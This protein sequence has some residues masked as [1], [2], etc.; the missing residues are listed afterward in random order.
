MPEIEP[1]TKHAKPRG[2]A[3]W[4]STTR[5]TSA[6]PSRRCSTWKATRWTAAEGGGEGLD[7]FEQATF[8][9]VLLD[10]MMPDRSGMEVLDEIRKRDRDTPI[11]LITAYGSVEVAV[12]ALKSGANDYFFE[13]LGQREA[14]DRDRP[15]DRA[16]ALEHENRS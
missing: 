3:S 13:A 5:R 9:L 6:N 11:F 1:L 4:S 14:A 10:L 12:E 15:A 2:A 16:H 8:D 7:R